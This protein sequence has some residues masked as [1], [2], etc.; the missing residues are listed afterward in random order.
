MS[1]FYCMKDETRVAGPWSDKDVPAFIPKHF[2][3]IE[4]RDWQKTLKDL[5]LKDLEDP[6]SRKI[7]FIVDPIGGHGKSV[8]ARYMKY[9]H[10]AI[11]LPSTLVT[12]EDVMQC[13]CAK[14]GKSHDARVVIVDF[15]RATAKSHWHVFARALETIKDGCAY[16]K[17]YS[18]TEVDFDTPAILCL[19]NAPPPSGVFSA[20][21]WEEFHLP[22]SV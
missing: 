12:A 1:E 9:Y 5:L 7:R 11:T 18:W 6:W 14:M 20:D 15:P 22:I 13:M 16:D 8:F 2:R 17:R 3:N 21:R 19:C 10:K 4:L